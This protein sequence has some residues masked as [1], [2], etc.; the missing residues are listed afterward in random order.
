[1][2]NYT[3]F[4]AFTGISPFEKLGVI[5]FLEQHIGVSKAKIQMA[6]EYAIKDCPSFGGLILVVT[7]AEEPVAVAIIHKAGANGHQAKHTLAYYAISEKFQTEEFVS[8]FFDK[9]INL[10]NGD[11]AMHL[12]ANDPVLGVF[13]KMGFQQHR[14]E[15]RFNGS[16]KLRLAV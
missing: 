9:L 8:D 2:G 15:Y 7:Q 4:D 10:S 13:Q 16:N 11:L 12:D 14:V 3:V 5:K 6:V 1:M